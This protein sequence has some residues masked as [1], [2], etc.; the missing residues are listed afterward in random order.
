V[1]ELSE[2][3][4][5]TRIVHA[6]QISFVVKKNIV[7]TK[8]N[9]LN[10][11]D[12]NVAFATIESLAPITTSLDQIRTKNWHISTQTHVTLLVW[13]FL[14]PAGRHEK[15]TSDRC[16]SLSQTICDMH[17]KQTGRITGTFH[18]T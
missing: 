15:S 6:Q 2:L 10:G 16:S 17:Q 4:C 9:E 1:V 18:H 8:T 12:Q 5:L 11:T 3:L 7:S 13:G 14:A